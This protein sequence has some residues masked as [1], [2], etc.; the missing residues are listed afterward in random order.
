[1]RADQNREATR[2]LRGH[3]AALQAGVPL[4][5]PRELSQRGQVAVG[6]HQL[7]EEPL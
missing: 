3:Q 4:L 7:R 6:V 2:M 1:M 5:L